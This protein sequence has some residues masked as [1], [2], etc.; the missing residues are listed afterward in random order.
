MKLLCHLGWHNWIYSLQGFS[1]ATLREYPRIA[2]LCTRCHR[3]QFYA[4]LGEWK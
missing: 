4:G 2:R 1:L 3:E